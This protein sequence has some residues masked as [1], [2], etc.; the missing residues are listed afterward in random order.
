VHSTT[1]RITLHRERVEAGWVSGAELAAGVTTVATTF[2]DAP[3]CVLIVL[4]DPAVTGAD[5]EGRRL[6]M[7][8]DGA[9]RATDAAGSERPPVLLS[10]DNR[11]VLAY[12]IVPESDDAG[13]PR[14]VVVSIASQQGWSLVG[15]MGSEALDARAAV[16]IVAARGLDGALLPLVPRD[17]AAA[18]AGSVMA[19]RL[20]WLGPS[21]GKAERQAARALAR[22]VA[23]PVAPRA[24]ARSPFAA[25]RMAQARPQAAAPRAAASRKK[26]G[27]R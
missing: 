8:L 13:R 5:I 12:E 26:T 18:S 3:R 10:L 2:T 14:R 22:G 17:P 1:P 20:L 19:S 16:A 11:S 7:G 24:L 23:Q 6:L 4:D 25:A 27:G 9:E 15:V 21:R